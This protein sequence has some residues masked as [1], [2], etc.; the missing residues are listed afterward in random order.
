[1]PKMRDYRALQQ[2][3]RRA[4]DLAALE[5]LQASRPLRPPGPLLL[6]ERTTKYTAR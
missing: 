4:E 3:S 6:E 5:V 2:L 1:M